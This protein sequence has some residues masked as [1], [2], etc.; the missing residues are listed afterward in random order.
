MSRASLISA[1]SVASLVFSSASFI[2]LPLFVLVTHGLKFAQKGHHLFAS[3]VEP[4]LLDAV[5]H[6]S[7]HDVIITLLQ[8]HTQLGHLHKP[9]GV[10]RLHSR[11]DEMVYNFGL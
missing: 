10:L 5:R 3:E 7:L 9:G 6:L 2:C 1:S 8:R 4:R 11:L